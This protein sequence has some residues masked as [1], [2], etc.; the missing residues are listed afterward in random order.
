[1]EQKMRE[2]LVNMKV[3]PYICGM[4]LEEF[5]RQYELPIYSEQGIGVWQINPMLLEH[6]GQIQVDSHAL[7]IVSHGVINV[8]IQNRDYKIMTNSYAEIADYDHLQLVSASDD[9][10][11]LCLF[12]TEE[13]FFLI[14]NH[15]PPSDMQYLNMITNEKILKVDKKGL[16][17]MKSVIETIGDTLGYT[18]HDYKDT[19]LQLKIKILY[20]EVNNLY[21]RLL[22]ERPAYPSN[23]NRQQEIFSQFIKLLM[24][25]A[26]QEHTVEYYA[27]ELCISTQY[28][29]RVVKNI[30]HRKVYDI[31]SNSVISEIKTMLADSSLTIKQIADEL[32]FTD[33]AVLSKY[34]KRHTRMSPREYRNSI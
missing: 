18:E 29:S 30:G 19:L 6:N 12:F 20:F 25:H 15:C 32:N 8:R 27:N 23:T 16:N 5:F 3:I 21:R 34:F 26:R 2:S 22:K 13:F 11:A 28:I 10:D 17:S 4:K 14:F 33:Y 7:I 1:M 9:A 24:E 31:I